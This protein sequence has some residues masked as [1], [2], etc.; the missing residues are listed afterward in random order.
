MTRISS[1]VGISPCASAR[2][3]WR[4]RATSIPIRPATTRSNAPSEFD[5][6]SGYGYGGLGIDLQYNFSSWAHAGVRAGGRLS[7][8]LRADM[9]DGTR[10]FESSAWGGYAGAGLG[11]HF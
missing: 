11:V 7:T 5:A 1:A 2:A 8:P 9:P 6:S 4:T 3:R 10:L